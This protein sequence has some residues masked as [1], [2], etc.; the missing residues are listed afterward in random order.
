M[1]FG[2]VTQFGLEGLVSDLMGFF[3]DSLQVSYVRLIIGIISLKGR[4]IL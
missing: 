2:T 3:T 4:K 1:K